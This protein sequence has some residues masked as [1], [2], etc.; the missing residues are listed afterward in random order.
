MIEIIPNWHP[1]LVHFTVALLSMA[2]FLHLLTLLPLPAVMRAEWK[3]VARWLLWLGA[4]FAIATAFTG[5]LA[6]NNVE[7]DD[8]SHA[9]MT[10]HRNWALTTLA[11]FLALAAWSL[12]D[13]LHKD[14]WSS[15]V[16]GILFSAVLGAGALLLSTTAWHGA[17]LV[18]RYGLGVMSLPNTAAVEH[19]PAQAPERTQPTAVPPPVIPAVKPPAQ[20]HSTHTH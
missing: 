11:L 2:V 19:S 9:A 4:L 16:P 10:V 3:V 8:V 7:H 14:Q 13:R 18:Y 5:W 12:W 15:G 1:L 20:D 17:E 6:Y